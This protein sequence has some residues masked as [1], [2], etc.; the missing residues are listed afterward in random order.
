LIVVLTQ[1]WVGVLKISLWILDQP[2][3]LTS[4]VLGIV[5][6]IG[7]AWANHLRPEAARSA[8]APA[9]SAAGRRTKQIM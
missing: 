4:A 3:A 5:F 9:K 1:D 7:S 2:L 8:L 6:A